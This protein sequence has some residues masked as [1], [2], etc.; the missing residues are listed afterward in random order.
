MYIWRKDSTLR[1]AEANLF[2]N[3]SN[4]NDN[5]PWV[6]GLLQLYRIVS[7]DARLVY[8]A[9]FNDPENSILILKVSKN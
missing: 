1:V 2:N 5:D 9:D 3:I 7:N 4:D 8:E 6:K